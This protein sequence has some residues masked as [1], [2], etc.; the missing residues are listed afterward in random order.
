MWR[1]EEKKKEK[2]GKRSNGCGSWVEGQRVG[3]LKRNLPR[4][5]WRD[6]EN[7]LTVSSQ[8]GDCIYPSFNRGLFGRNGSVK[9]VC[10]GPLVIRW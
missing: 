5:S 10:E 2:E 9:R 6:A 3:K 1:N 4:V 7:F 8:S